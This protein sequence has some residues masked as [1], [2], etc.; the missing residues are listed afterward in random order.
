VTSIIYRTAKM[1]ADISM[2]GP[3]DWSD[4]EV[5]SQLTSGLNAQI[6]MEKFIVQNFCHGI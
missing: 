5:E 1:G 6:V 3:T 4:S 2:R